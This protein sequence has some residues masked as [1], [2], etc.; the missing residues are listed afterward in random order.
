MSRDLRNVTFGDLWRAPCRHGYAQRRNCP[1]CHEDNRVNAGKRK[2]KF[3][4]RRGSVYE[5]DPK[6]DA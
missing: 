4:P 6:E 1:R 3:D 5:P 2:P